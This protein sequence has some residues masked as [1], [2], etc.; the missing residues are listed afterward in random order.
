VVPPGEVTRLFEPFQQLD[1]QRARL[2]AGHGLGLA[3]VA[4]IAAAHDAT[5]DASPRTEGG[6]DITVRFPR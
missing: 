4:A 3:I 2:S 1:G 5:L 6:L